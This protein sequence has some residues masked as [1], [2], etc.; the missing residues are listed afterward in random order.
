[1]L[2]GRTNCFCPCTP[3]VSTCVL[4]PVRTRLSLAL[5]RV[6][7]QENRILFR[8]AAGN[9]C[10]AFKS[11]ALVARKMEVL[12]PQNQS[13]DGK[14]YLCLL[15]YRNYCVES[16][17]VNL[18]SGRATSVKPSSFHFCYDTTSFPSAFLTRLNP[19]LLLFTL[20]SHLS[21]MILKSSCL[22][23]RQVL[24]QKLYG[25]SLERHGCET[26][27]AR[28]VFSNVNNSF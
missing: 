22:N 13:S 25:T 20:I 8:F 24:P 2:N 12:S 23:E 11:S 6:A 3:K 4:V 26:G 21:L 16:L 27:E 17:W 1:M 10:W 7:E 28:V 19:R 14:F 9:Q 18:N 15:E 5:A